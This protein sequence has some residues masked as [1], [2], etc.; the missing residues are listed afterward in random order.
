MES[1]ED[2]GIK[3]IVVAV[4]TTDYSRMVIARA[5][6]IAVAFSAETHIISVVQLPRLVASE[7][8]VGI[9]EVRIDEKQYA[10]HQKSLIDE[11]L[12]GRDLPVEAHILHGD[13]SGK[14]LEYANDIG[15]DLIIMGSKAYGKVHRLL[16]G[17]VSEDVVRNAKCSVM[18]AR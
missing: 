7:A 3:R 15:A 16:L 4:D 5:V 8:D 6:A 10:E 2:Y 17:G 18:I 1:I 13:P 14:I 12:L 9:Q 11:F